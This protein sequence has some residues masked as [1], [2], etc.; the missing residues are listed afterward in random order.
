ML[1]RPSLWIEGLPQRVSRKK[2]MNENKS[3]PPDSMEKTRRVNMTTQNFSAFSKPLSK[4]SAARRKR[5]TFDLIT[6]IPIE[7][8][9]TV[10]LDTVDITQAQ[11]ESARIKLTDPDKSKVSDREMQSI[12]KKC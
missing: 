12:L 11:Q 6:G 1:L 9:G 10:E 5:E 8:R 7:G 2:R 3:E 4:E